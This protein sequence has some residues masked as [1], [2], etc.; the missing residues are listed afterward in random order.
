MG[1]SDIFFISLCVSHLDIFAYLYIYK[2]IMTVLR[3]IRLRFPL[4]LLFTEIPLTYCMHC[5]VLY[6]TVLYCTYC[7]DADE[8]TNSLINCHTDLSDSFFVLSMRCDFFPLNFFTR[9][10][11]YSSLSI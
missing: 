3:A 7:T 9:F 1:S 2:L 6:S 11:L 10:F 8:R 4:K 5:T